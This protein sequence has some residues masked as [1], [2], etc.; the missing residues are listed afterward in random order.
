VNSTL[1]PNFGLAIAKS[2]HND[3]V[4]D[5]RKPRNHQRRQR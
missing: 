4:A 1:H 2:R 3:L 5:R